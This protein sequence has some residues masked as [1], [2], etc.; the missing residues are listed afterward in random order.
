MLKA[1]STPELSDYVDDVKSNTRPNRAP[2]FPPT[3]TDDTM[4]SD[5]CGDLAVQSNVGTENRDRTSP[6]RETEPEPGNQT[7]A[8]SGL[9]SVNTLLG[10]I[11][12]L[13]FL[14]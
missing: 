6:G 12:S 9:Y 3:Y 10:I 11:G 7:Q 5:N 8:K 1:R 13:T 4:P 2:S 14:F